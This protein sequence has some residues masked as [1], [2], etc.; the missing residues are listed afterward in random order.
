[1]PNYKITLKQIFAQMSSDLT[2]KDS[3]KGYLPT[4]TWMANQLGHFGLGLTTFLLLNCLFPYFGINYP[5]YIYLGA[6]L[7]WCLF[8]TW[9]TSYTLI[10]DHKNGAF[11]PDYCIIFKDL[12]LDLSFFTFGTTFGYSTTQG[13][14]W[15]IVCFFGLLAIVLTP[16]IMWFSRIMYFQQGNFASVYLRL[17]ETTFEPTDQEKTAILDFC[18]LKGDTHCIFIF[19]NWESGKTRLATAI[20]SEYAL[21]RGITRYLTLFN[22]MQEL[23]LPNSYQFGKANQIWPWRQASIL[24]IDDVDPSIPQLEMVTPD[25][26]K[27]ALSI[28]EYCSENIQTLKNNRSVWV[29]GTNDQQSTWENLFVETGIVTDKNHILSLNLSNV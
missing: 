29:F 11:K 10:H 19:G 24:V 26:F 8:E 7:V 18:Q 9:N 13:W 23:T 27:K 4:Y 2:G 20:A 22:W 6:T 14:L 5:F 25:D 17:S 3:V 28:G 12:A 15:A 1:M 21:N 16:G